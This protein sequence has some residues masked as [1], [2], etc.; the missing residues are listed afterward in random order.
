MICFEAVSLYEDQANDILFAL[1]FVDPG[2]SQE[3]A[4]MGNL[5][6]L[7]SNYVS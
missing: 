5:D 6:K 4:L 2:S 1:S 7:G 3:T